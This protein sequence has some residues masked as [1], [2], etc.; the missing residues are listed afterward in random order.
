GGEE[1]VVL[2]RCAGA[3]AAGHAFERL[4][5]NT[6]AFVFPQVGRLT[7]SIGFTKIAAG[8]SPSSALERADR[9]VYHAKA[10]G[11]NQVCSH[12]DLIAS[13]QLAAGENVGE[14]ELF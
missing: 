13:G 4:R 12:S 5:K 1:F 14:I 9:A 8:D 6:E 2:M 10:K 11:R 7:V 3:D